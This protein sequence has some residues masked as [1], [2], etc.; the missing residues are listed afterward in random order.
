WVS[1]NACKLS[2]VSPDTC[3]FSR[4]GVNTAMPA[5]TS[6]AARA[7]TRLNSDE[8]RCIH[9]RCR[10]PARCLAMLIGC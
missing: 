8:C 9:W 2:R 1:A 4:V 7:P 10:S 6:G 5:L 3:E